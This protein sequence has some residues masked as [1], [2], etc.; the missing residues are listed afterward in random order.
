MNHRT[1]GRRTRSRRRAPHPSRRLHTLDRTDRLEWLARAAASA[2][3]ARA[4]TLEPPAP[5]LELT[6]SV[7]SDPTTDTDILWHIARTAPEL[8]RWL[9][10]NPKADATLLEYVSQAGGPGVKRALT[11]LLDSLDALDGHRCRAR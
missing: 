6:P 2:D 10:A 3:A 8:R 4:A 5:P 11:V 7:A 1:A 9:V